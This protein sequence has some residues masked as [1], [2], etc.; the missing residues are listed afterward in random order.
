MAVVSQV[1]AKRCWALCAAVSRGRE[2]L[3]ADSSCYF[4][5]EVRSDMERLVSLSTSK[6]NT[7]DMYGEF[8]SCAAKLKI[9]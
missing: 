2:A 1:K 4:D 3:T 7:K 6:V 9:S 5:T 8:L